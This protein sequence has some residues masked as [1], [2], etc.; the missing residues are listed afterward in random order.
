MNIDRRTLRE[1]HP[2]Y[3]ELRDAIHTHLRKVLSQ[4]RSE[5]YKAANVERRDQRATSAIQDV[6][7]VSRERIAPV[8]Q[9]AAALFERGWE[10]AVEQPNVRKAL[11]KRYSVAELYE[12]VIDAA[13]GV[14][15]EDQLS[16]I[17]R[18]L[19]NRLSE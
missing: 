14:I 19:T 5:L 10:R 12:A 17:L 2:A 18:R 11:L 4:A 1:A 6:I 13:K 7:E 8:S 9:K 15:T 16:E 3:V